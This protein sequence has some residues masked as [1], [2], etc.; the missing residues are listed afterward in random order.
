MTATTATAYQH[1]AEAPMPTAA[2]TC[3]YSSSTWTYIATIADPCA[4]TATFIGLINL[5]QRYHPQLRLQLILLPLQLLNTNLPSRYLDFHKLQQEV[6][7]IPGINVSTHNPKRI[8]FSTRHRRFERNASPSN[9]HQRQS[10]RHHDQ[11]Q[12]DGHQ[13]ARHIIDQLRSG[14]DP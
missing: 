11:R 7:L 13:E 12:A 1:A 4:S 6:L 5:C 10:Q 8:C 2:P 3:D 14:R 9:L